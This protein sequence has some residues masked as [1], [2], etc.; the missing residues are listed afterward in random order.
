M[1]ELTLLIDFYKNLDRLG[2][3]GE[4]ETL[5]AWQY[6]GLAP[7]LAVVADIGCGTGSQTAVIARQPGVYKVIAVDFI[8]EFLKSAQRRFKG[9]ELEV[10]T[11]Q[12]DMGALPFEPAS[13]N[14]IWS[15]GAAYNIGFANAARCWN[16]FLKAGGFIAVT[17]LSWLTGNRPQPLLDYWAANYPDIE[18]IA[19]NVVRLEAAGYEIISHFTLP[20][21]CWTE[22][23]YSPIQAQIEPF[24]AR[25]N[26]SSE[27][28]AFVNSVKEEISVYEK[29]GRLY[30]Y[31]FYI[32]RKTREAN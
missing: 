12:A 17:E 29:Y 11:L 4:P 1:D 9:E 19:N 23:Y 24:L 32:A 13:L 6:V 20:P 15:E 27:A 25:W 14:V 22:N 10:Q 7:S 28:Q 8:G 18:S 3:G 26:Y 31:E 2:P 5:R 30:G 21:H 16:P